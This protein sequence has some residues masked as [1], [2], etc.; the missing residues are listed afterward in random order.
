METYHAYLHTYHTY[1]D[2]LRKK[3]TRTFLNTC[4]L[5][6]ACVSYVQW[7]Q[8]QLVSG[9]QRVCKCVCCWSCY[10][11]TCPHCITAMR[12]A[13]ASWPHHPFLRHNMLQSYTCA[14]RWF[15]CYRPVKGHYG[16]EILMQMCY[17][18]CDNLLIETCFMQC[19]W[20]FPSS[21]IQWMW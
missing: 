21:L 1:I 5:L 17:R 10:T 16:L 8:G 20:R 6:Q 11:A 3:F 13:N 14:Q 2:T 12:T 9:S 19:A 7:W 15:W 4:R 18:T